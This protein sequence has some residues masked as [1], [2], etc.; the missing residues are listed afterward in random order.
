VL[1]SLNH[2]HIA[3][4]SGFEDANGVKALVMEWSMA[5]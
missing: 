2:P 3:A 1:A 5:C 4:I